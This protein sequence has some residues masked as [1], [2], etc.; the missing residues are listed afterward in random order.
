M[1]SLVKGRKKH[2]KTVPSLQGQREVKK[3]TFEN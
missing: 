2:V 1:I 3:E